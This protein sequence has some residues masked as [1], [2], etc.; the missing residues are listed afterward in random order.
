MM[1]VKSIQIYI[2]VVYQ[3]CSSLDCSEAKGFT[4]IH[5][6]RVPVANTR[7]LNRERRNLK[8]R[9]THADSRRTGQGRESSNTTLAERDYQQLKTDIIPGMFQPGATIK[10]KVV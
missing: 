5:F 8:S 7:S 6:S 3:C 2:S 10:A 4:S 9:R 1:Y